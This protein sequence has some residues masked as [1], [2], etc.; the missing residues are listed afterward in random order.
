MEISSRF[1]NVCLEVLP[2]EIKRKEHY[3]MWEIFNK[4]KNLI[5]IFVFN[6]EC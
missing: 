5:I 2:N 3:H 4:L 6:F 1:R